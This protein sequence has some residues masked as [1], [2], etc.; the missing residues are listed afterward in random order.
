M[1]RNIVRMK[2]KITKIIWK[3]ETEK[4][5]RRGI[6][7]KRWNEDATVLKELLKKKELSRI[8]T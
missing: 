4:K 3:A 6:L 2:K 7:R 5:R 1:V 8:Q